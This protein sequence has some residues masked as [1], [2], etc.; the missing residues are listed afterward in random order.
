MPQKNQVQVV[1][2][3]GKDIIQQVRWYDPAITHG[4]VDAVFEDLKGATRRQR[5]FNGIDPNDLMQYYRE[6]DERIRG[7][8]DPQQ[9][10]YRNTAMSDQSLGINASSNELPN[11]IGRHALLQLSSHATAPSKGVHK[12]DDLMQFMFGSHQEKEKIK[13]K[14]TNKSNI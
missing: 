10:V 5:H 4:D 7:D 13:E 9:G 14:D 3:S 12:E 1:E 8:Y 2:S 6:L 11:V